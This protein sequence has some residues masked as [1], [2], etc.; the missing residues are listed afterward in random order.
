MTTALKAV[1]TVNLDPLCRSSISHPDPM[2]KVMAFHHLY[3]VPMAPFGSTDPQ[4]SHMTNE[5]VSLRLGLISEEFK[6]LFEDG[7]GINAEITYVVPNHASQ[8]AR[9]FNEHAMKSGHAL[10]AAEEN[11]LRRNGVEVA[12]ALAD[13][14]YVIYGFAVELGYDLRSVIDEVHASNMTKAGPDG[15]AILRAD[16]KVL[17]GDDYQKANIPAAL[18]FRAD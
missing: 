2:V 3:D 9:P 18:G 14:V 4:F 13:L 5:R 15:R 12:D 1:E 11:K 16:G 8:M 10:N 6:E 7:F 17:K